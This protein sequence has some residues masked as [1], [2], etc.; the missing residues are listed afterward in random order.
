MLCGER[1][2]QFRAV[3]VVE[4][5]V[6][7]TS[8]PY[9]SAALEIDLHLLRGADVR[10]VRMLRGYGVPTPRIGKWIFVCI[11]RRKSLT[12]ECRGGSVFHGNVRPASRSL[13]PSTYRRLESMAEAC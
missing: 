13:S 6:N 5:V 2:L 7:C 8:I 12:K 11:I 9:G 4:K 1:M 10:V 3:G